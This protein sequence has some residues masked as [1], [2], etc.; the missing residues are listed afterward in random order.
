M[1]KSSL[2]GGFYFDPGD[3]KDNSCGEGFSDENDGGEDDSSGGSRDEDDDQDYKSFEAQKL[4]RHS[5]G[6]ILRSPEQTGA[7]KSNFISMPRPYL[8]ASD[9]MKVSFPAEL[10]QKLEKIFCHESP[11]IPSIYFSLYYDKPNC[12][13]TV[14]IKKASHISTACPVESSNPFVMAYLLPNKNMVQQSSIMECTHDPIFNYIFKFFCDDV[15][16]QVL[17]I[18]LYVNDIDHFIG[19]VLHELEKT[20]LFGNNIV[21]EILAFDEQ[22]CSMVS[23]RNL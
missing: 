12:C 3:L 9:S 20:D 7:T 5:I 4:T 13:L 18:K 6:K 23:F 11:E 2:E 16:G 1:S 8:L 19:G 10:N 15:V 17:V 22:L 14:H 21:Q